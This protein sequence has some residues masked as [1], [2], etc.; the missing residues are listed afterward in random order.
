MCNCSINDQSRGKSGTQFSI[1]PLLH[2][3]TVINVQY[4][5]PIV[6]VQYEHVC[7]IV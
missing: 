1:K 6:T 2:S 4:D 3:L 5:F 7:V